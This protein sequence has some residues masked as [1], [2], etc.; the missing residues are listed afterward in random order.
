MT[1]QGPRTEVTEEVPGFNQT[2]KGKESGSV[3]E[4]NRGLGGK[5]LNGNV[6]S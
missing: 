1:G 5:E 4:E 2:A 3:G 6:F